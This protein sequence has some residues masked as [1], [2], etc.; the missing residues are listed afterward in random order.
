MTLFATALERGRSAALLSDVAAAHF[1]LA[2]E[3]DRPSALVDG[4]EAAVEAT[5]LDPR[6][7]AAQFNRGLLCRE[8]GLR[9]CSR[10]AWSEYLERDARSPWADEVRRYQAQLLASAREPEKARQQLRDALARTDLVQ[11]R[12]LASSYPTTAARWV[13]EEL[14]DQW[15]AAALAGEEAKADELRSRALDLAQVLERQGR[16]TGLRRVIEP[17]AAPQ[18][19]PRLALASGHRRYAEGIRQLG[20]GD[21]PAARQRFAEAEGALRRG[22]SPLAAEAELQRITCLILETSYASALAAAQRVERL[23]DL[24]PA[25]AARAAWLRAI[26]E[27]PLRRPLDAIASYRRAS[28]LYTRAG[29]VSNLVNTD[30]RLAEML[31]D[32][33]QREEAWRVRRRALKG[34]EGLEDLARRPFVWGAAADAALAGGQVRV[35]RL[36]QRQ[37]LFEAR[38]AGRPLWLAEALRQSANVHLE[39]GRDDEARADLAE[40][41]R[42]VA[43]AKDDPIRQSIELKLEELQGR[44][45]L[46]S[47]PQA[48]RR[49]FEAAIREVSRLGQQVLL[50]ALLVERAQAL[51]ALGQGGEV[52]RALRAAVALIEEEW[53]ASLEHRLGSDQ[54]PLWPTYFGSRR[55]PFDR[56]IRRLY[57]AGEIEEALSVAEKAR[58]REVLDLLR[59][60]AALQPGVRRLFAGPARPLGAGELVARLPART[61]L[62]EYAFADEQLLTWVVGR[63]GVRFAAAQPAREIDELVKDL[64]PTLRSS[65]SGPGIR[66]DLAALFDRLVAPFA[67]EIHPRER[68]V[69]VADGVLHGLPFAALYDRSARRYWIEDHPISAAPSATLYVY[70]VSRD[71]EL[72][73]EMPPS[74]LAIGDPAFDPAQFPQLRRLQGSDEESRAVAALYTR[75]LVLTAERASKDRFLAELGRHSVVH[76][77]GHAIGHPWAAFLVLAPEAPG[78]SSSLYASELLSR[79]GGRTRLVFLSA[80]S[81]MGEQEAG[82]Q[83]VAALVRPLVGAGIPA[84]VGT[85]WPVDDRVAVEIGKAFH[86]HLLAG[87]DVPAALQA[88]QVD[89]LR[90]EL[91]VLRLPQSWAAFG[92]VGHASLGEAET[93]D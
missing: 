87:K 90:H 37:G 14:L 39:A 49:H 92:V 23:P 4:L 30:T 38:R 47:D 32:V 51:E 21:L 35:A 64:G 40:A 57:D 69:V 61:V 65:A 54:D 55:R 62:V 60:P 6:L 84:V 15:A 56:L 34:V 85:L 22:G 7:P 52:R 17:L 59:G 31:D 29:D 45:A 33:H 78:E 73:V 46:A 93:E 82:G 10:E 36:F 19:A 86:R 67:D 88:A 89:L 41:A 81:S 20:G 76:F 53:E 11:L 1:V 13:V 72:R 12:H 28:D 83:G 91:L 44:A 9:E 26:G 24:D 5:A 43:D 74:V 68:V 80:C 18:R 50:S 70:S 27:T 8:L 75:S 79:P 25:V 63:D 58:A 3:L 16:S 48:A 66:E 42:L 71:R 2:Q 77:A